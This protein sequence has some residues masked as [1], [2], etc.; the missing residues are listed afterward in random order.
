MTST[1]PRGRT[2]PTSLAKAAP[3]RYI[4]RNEPEFDHRKSASNL[5]VYWFLTL[6]LC[7][8]TRR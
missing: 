7:L 2:R 4:L 8:A 3:A 5:S 1:D 6:V